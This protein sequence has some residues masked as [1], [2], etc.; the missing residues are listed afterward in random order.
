MNAAMSQSCVDFSAQFGGGDAA[1]AVPPHFKALKAA[2]RGLRLERFPFPKLAFILRVDGE[3]TLY[4]F[5]GAGNLDIDK[6]GDYLSVDIG[7]NHDDRDRLV[8]VITSAIFSSGE[9][10]K[11]VAEANS[12]IIDF[13]ALQRCLVNLV[14]RYKNE[15]TTQ[16]SDGRR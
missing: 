6:G 5:S 13:E 10:M 11:P 15:L 4:G 8:D 14:A 1:T 3:V 12:W 2:A 16:L 9:Q 7:I